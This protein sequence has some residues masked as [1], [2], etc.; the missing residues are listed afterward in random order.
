M[1]WSEWIRSIWQQPF[2][3]MALASAACFC[4]YQQRIKGGSSAKP[5]SLLSRVILSVVL[6]FFVA[7]L[8]GRLNHPAVFD[9]SAFYLY[10]KA[11]VLGYDVYNPEH[12]GKIFSGLSD[13]PPLDYREFTEEIVQTGAMYSP[14]SMLLYAPF[15]AMTYP[16]A[17]KAWMV[18]TWLFIP[19]CIH[20]IIRIWFPGQGP[21]AW[22]LVATLV[23]LLGASRQTVQFLQ[24]NF[25]TLYLLL[26]MKRYEHRPIAGVFLALGFLV[27][28]YMAF[29]GLV[30]LFR[31]QWKTL[32]AAAG[33]GMAY[34]LLTLVLWGKGPFLSYL[35]DNPSKRLPAWVFREPIN[36]SL[37][38]VLLRMNLV[39]VI[40]SPA[41]TLIA[42]LLLGLT[43]YLLYRLGRRN[44]NSWHWI[45]V[46]LTALLVYPGTLSYY[47]V[48]LL[49]VLFFLLRESRL[50]EA[51][52]GLKSG[53]VGCC[54]L[55]AAGSFFAAVVFLQ[56]LALAI[57]FGPD[58]HTGKSFFASDSTK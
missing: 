43:L 20:Q 29:F 39:S 25:I 47:G 15:G 49:F 14:P 6:V 37:H 57:C 27:K 54:F 58:V 7:K 22:I 2:T 13:L 40:N 1:N 11:A 5:Y 44:M 18:F 48:M 33:T 55:L 8:V 34:C 17:E 53:L 19:L 10:G 3:A 46:L 35:F 32:L 42:G 51:S 23:L 21:K 52:T 30:F 24:T 4:F 56:L 36:Q 9:F 16:V 31:K 45:F 41:Y 12:L 38:A 50:A 28:P 26:L